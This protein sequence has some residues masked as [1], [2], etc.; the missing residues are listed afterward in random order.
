MRSNPQFFEALV[1]E[2]ILTD[3]DAEKLRIKFDDDAFELLLHL[4]KGGAS[5]KDVLGK[6]WADT[7]NLSYVNLDK[8]LFQANAVKQLSEEFARQHRVIPIYEIEDTLT[9]A[10]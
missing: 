10:M 9:I 2:T 5:S 3:D 1:K 7:F 4:M 6:L 8:T